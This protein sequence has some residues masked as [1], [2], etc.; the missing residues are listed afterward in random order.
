MLFNYFK[1][2]W[3]NMIKSKT[4]SF[5]NI[6]GLAAGLTCCMLISIYLLHEFSYDRN[7]P[8]VK[9]LYQMATTFIMNHKEFR[10]ANVP[11]PM[12]A[13]V[14]KEF[15]EV[16]QYTRLM[17]LATFEDK[18]MLQ[19]R[20]TGGRAVS[21][22][23]SKGFLADSSFFRMFNFHFIEGDAASSLDAPNTMVVS[24]TIAHK[25]F[26]AAPALG[27]IVHISSG[28]DG[29]RDLVVKG[30]FRPTGEPSHMDGNFFLSFGGGGW[31]IL[32]AGR[33]TILRPTICSPSISGW[34]RVPNLLL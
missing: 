13:T 33:R 12:G 22:Y 18:T 9:N 6:F 10:L 16:R 19:Y 14:K 21:F 23:E 8:D 4:F 34:R 26:G 15:P 24:E 20:A 31:K 11:A 1:I 32:R 29:D 27:K 2:A 28:T 5:I 17:Q 25:L 30:V 3:R 7:Q